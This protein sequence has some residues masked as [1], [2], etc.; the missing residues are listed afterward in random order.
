MIQLRVLKQGCDTVLGDAASDEELFLTTDVESFELSQIKGK[1]DAKQRQRSWDLAKRIDYFAEDSALRQKNALVKTTNKGSLEL[2]WSKE[3]VPE[4]GMFRDIP[5]SASDP[6]S[7]GKLL[8]EANT[9]VAATDSEDEEP[10][11][12]ATEDGI[13]IDGTEY[14]VGQF[15]FVGPDVFDQ[16]PE[17]VRDLEVPSYLKNS[18]HHKGSHEG[19]RAWGI[20]RIAQVGSGKQAGKIASGEDVSSIM[21]ERFWRPEDISVELADQAASYYALYASAGKE[22]VK[23]DVEDVVGPVTVG[24]VAHNDADDTFFCVGTFNRKTKKVIEAGC[25]P[26]ELAEAAVADDKAK[27]HGGRVWQPQ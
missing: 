9:K 18:R 21:L 14:K 26:E 8:K 15:V 12:V 16:M 24:S 2:F 27:A 1:L 3:Y 7:L 4:E 5:S 6:S 22:E 19:L 11:A 17:A 25:V 20:G 13:I 10:L 23:V